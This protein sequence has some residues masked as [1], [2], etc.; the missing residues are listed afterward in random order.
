MMEVADLGR[1]LL[2]LGGVIVLVGLLLMLSGSLPF[3]GRLPGDLSF[4]WGSVRLF[5]P[6]ATMI[7]LS[8]VLTILLNLLGGAFRR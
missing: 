4:E 5:I 1:T 3:I 2:V 8:V 7:L 6:L